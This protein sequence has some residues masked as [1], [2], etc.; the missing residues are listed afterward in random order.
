MVHTLSVLLVNMF[1]DPPVRLTDGISDA[2]GRVEVFHE[3]VGWGTICNM[4][5]SVSDADVVCRQLGFAEGQNH[6]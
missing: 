3:K 6:A 4:E 2:H 1:L 5:W